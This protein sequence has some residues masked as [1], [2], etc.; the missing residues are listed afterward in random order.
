[1]LCHLFLPRA[2]LDEGAAAGHRPLFLMS[3]LQL[4]RDVQVGTPAYPAINGTYVDCTFG[5]GGHSRALLRDLTQ[6]SRLYAL[7]VDRQAIKVARRVAKM[8]PR[9]IVHKTSYAQLGSVLGG[10]Q[11]PTSEH[12]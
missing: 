4:F 7:D 2:A 11:V 6:T 9:L 10:V 1:M 8:D 3:V 5:R 12:L